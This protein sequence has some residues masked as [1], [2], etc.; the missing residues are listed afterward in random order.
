MVIFRSIIERRQFLLKNMTEI[1]GHIMYSE[2]KEL[3]VSKFKNKIN[4]YTL[5]TNIYKLYLL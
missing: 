2:V 5:I 4:K 3:H 1:K